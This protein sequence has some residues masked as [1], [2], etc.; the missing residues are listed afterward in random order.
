MNKITKKL[1]F[2]TCPVFD[3]EIEDYDTFKKITSYLSFCKIR[4]EIYFFYTD[5]NDNP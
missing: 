3:R 2:I 4:K 1:I 5:I